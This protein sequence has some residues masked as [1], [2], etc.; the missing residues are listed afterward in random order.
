MLGNLNIDNFHMSVISGGIK[1]RE[2]LRVDD[3]G[4]SG[5]SHGSTGK[6]NPQR[7]W[8]NS[9]GWRV[10]KGRWWTVVESRG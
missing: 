9:L 2:R 5:I 4:R 3:L 6:L 7:T 1:G 8:K 10:G